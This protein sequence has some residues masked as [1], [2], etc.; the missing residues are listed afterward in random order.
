MLK[1]AK[2]ALLWSCETFGLSASL[3]KSHW[4]RN[5]LLILAYHGISQEDEHLWAPELYMPPEFFRERLQAI[6]RAGCKV[7][8]LN[9]AIKRLYAGDLPERCVALT[10]DD[11][12]SDFYTQAYPILQEYGYPATVYLTTFY[13]DYNRPVFEGACSYLLWKRR[14]IRLCLKEVTGE[15]SIFDLSTAAASAEALKAVID[16]AC[17]NQMSAPAKDELA[18]RL[19]D[20]LGLDYEAF[21][22]RRIVQVL[23]PERV[24][25][26]AAWGVDIQLHTHR[27]RSPQDRQ[28]LAREIDDNRRRIAALAGIE[29]E[30]LC[31]PDGLFYADYLQWL[32][33]M[34]VRSATTCEPGLASADSHPM[35]LPRLVDT[36][37]L[38]MTEFKGWLNGISDF[39]PQRAASM[40]R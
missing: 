27:H 15:D 31:Y 13:C 28:Q 30:H 19:A 14:G 35:R 3:A 18:A 21:V 36:S 6:K 12:A 22:A 37:L 2:K 33:E 40:M 29:A 20:A 24:K 23:S 26:L 17:R 39:L 1:E 34:G 8:P 25:E 38:S 10:F 32:P 16:F 5:R 11:G 4:R 9:D 7:L